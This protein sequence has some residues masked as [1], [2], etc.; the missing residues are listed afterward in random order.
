VTLVAADEINGRWWG[1]PVAT[2]ADPAFFAASAGEQ[3]AALAPYAWAQFRAPLDAA[4]DP[5]ALARAGFAFADAQHAFRIRLAAAPEGSSAARA[6]VASADAQPFTPSERPTRPFAHE[7]FA[8][9]RG[10]TP[11]R[12]AARYAAWA[13]QLAREQPE[14]CVE[15]RHEG[16]PQGWFCSRQAGKGLELTLAA[17]YDDATLSGATLYAAALG[18]YAA[19]GARIGHAAFS[20]TNHD[21]HAIYAGL[22]ARFTSVT[23]FWLWQSD[24]APHA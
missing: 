15:V 19:R 11:E 14:W 1:A 6:E 13:D 12:L 17:L 24:E 4:P 20:I 3:A 22:G 9:L 16:T 5:W 7:R 2:V 23:G 21:V 10:S 18:A 8:L